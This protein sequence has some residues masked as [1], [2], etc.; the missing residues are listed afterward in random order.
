MFDHV[1]T[2]QKDVD[3]HA[4]EDDEDAAGDHVAC[5]VPEDGVSIVEAVKMSRGEG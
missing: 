2:G 5:H 1:L 3:D 4:I